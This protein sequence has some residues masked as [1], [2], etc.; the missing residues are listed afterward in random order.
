[1]NRR[2][3]LPKVT[4]PSVRRPS[5]LRVGALVVGAAA[6]AG[7]IALDRVQPITATPS[8]GVPLDHPMPYLVDKATAGTWFCSG[9]P[10]SAP[11]VG[12][13]SVFNPTESPIGAVIDVAPWKATSVRK[14]LS[15]PARARV[16]VSSADAGAADF[17]AA[18]VEISGVGGV[19]EQLSI[20][21]EGTTSS[22]CASAASSSWFLAEG[23]TALGDALTLTLY[24]PYAADAIVDLSFA[25]E[26]GPRKSKK[27]EGR[28]VP[29][30][31]VVVF[32]VGDVIQRKRIVSVVADV[33]SGL[34]VMGRHQTYGGQDSKRRGVANG[35]AVPSAS[36]SWRFANNQ[37]GGDPPAAERLVIFNPNDVEMIVNAT[38][39]PA[40]APAAVVAT[41]PNQAPIDPAT[42]VADPAADGAN[43]PG[44]AVPEPLSVAIG[45]KQVGEI[46]LSLATAVADGVYSIIVSSASPVVVERVLDRVVGGAALT[47]VQAGTRLT[48]TRWYVAAPPGPAAV[49]LYV[50]NATGD[51]TKST[52]SVKAIG[53]AGAVAVPGLE[54]V[55]IAPGERV[56]VNLDEKNVGGEMLLIEGV[57]S[58]VVERVITTGSSISASLGVPVVAL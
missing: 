1:M 13:F 47:T 29:A 38:V 55:P 32:P 14:T 31:S 20:T 42:G 53:P 4:R 56:R 23:S 50:L 40:D 11:G 54:E 5:V 30:R 58:L 17:A 48:S 18:T 26:E 34:V 46:D 15:I 8:F 27:F 21:P 45:P 2:M 3:S 22:A 19:V 49:I 6:I 43:K 33:R 16:D 41:D 25:D 9:V 12:M 44:P 37:K 35:V 51:T 24:N 57:T 52:F 39:L 36:T 28:V 7:G 10:A